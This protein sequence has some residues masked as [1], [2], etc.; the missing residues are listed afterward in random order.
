[1]DIT[2]LQK[3]TIAEWVK[4]GETIAIIQRRLREEMEMSLT[5]MDV[6]FLVD[7]LNLVYS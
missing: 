1:M 2:E 7:D 6:R 4:K 5:Y 3:S